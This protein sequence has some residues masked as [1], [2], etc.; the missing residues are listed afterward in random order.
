MTA[1][2]PVLPITQ[3]GR[4]A[5]SSWTVPA[6]ASGTAPVVVCA[7]PDG[8]R[9]ILIF[10]APRTNSFDIY[11]S[12]GGSPNPNS[13]IFLRPGTTIVLDTMVPQNEIRA[14]ADPTATSNQYLNV[15]YCHESM[16]V[17]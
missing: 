8:I 1:A 10:S 7:E 9:K 17:Q 14:I 13:P 12:F 5:E 16:D 11:I 6:Y 3:Y 15:A 2:C 4:V